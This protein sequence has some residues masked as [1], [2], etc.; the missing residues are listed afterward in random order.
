VVVCQSLGFVA[1]GAVL[2]VRRQSG[3]P[4]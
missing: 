1:D 2:A 4:L 3:G